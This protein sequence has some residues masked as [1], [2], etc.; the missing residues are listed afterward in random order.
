M[1]AQNSALT[2]RAVVDTQSVGYG[3]DFGIW[4]HSALMRM[5]QGDAVEACR[6]ANSAAR[7]M[8]V[9][10]D[11]LLTLKYRRAT[12]AMGSN[13]A[14]A[15]ATNTDRLCTGWVRTKRGCRA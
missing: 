7:L 5:R 9:F 15:A 8:S 11:G 4:C 10:Q 1:C 12:S 14:A 13:I 3:G 6:L 2:F